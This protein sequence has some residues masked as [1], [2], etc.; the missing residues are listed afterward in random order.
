MHNSGELYGIT[1][2]DEL[3]K[4][5]KETG[6]GTVVGPLVDLNYAQDIAFDRDFDI[7]YGTLYS[8]NRCFFATI[9]VLTEK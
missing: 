6:A 4:I 3:V 5:N 2:S 7:L 9:D 1:L 8:V